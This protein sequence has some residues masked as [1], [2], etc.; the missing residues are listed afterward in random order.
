MFRN[1]NKKR[2]EILEEEVEVLEDK[3]RSMARFLEI[4]WVS[5]SEW[6]GGEYKKFG[7]VSRK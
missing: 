5:N 7:K 3:V 1:N 2:I 4:D 6:E